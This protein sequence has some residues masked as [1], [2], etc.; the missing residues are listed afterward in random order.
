MA[1]E[2]DAG[3]P[4]AEPIT[5]NYTSDEIRPYQLHVDNRAKIIRVE[6]TTGYVNGSWVEKGSNVTFIRIAGAMRRWGLGYGPILAALL[7][8]NDDVCDP[9]MERVEIERIASNA[10]GYEP[11]NSDGEAEQDEG[12]SIRVEGGP[13]V[14]VDH[15]S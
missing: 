10:A 6:S 1:D 13:M 5:Q 4:L 11:E 12:E 14:K 7:L 3:E 15:G 8:H 2:F 9:P